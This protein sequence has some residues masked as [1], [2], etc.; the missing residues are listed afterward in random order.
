MNFSKKFAQVRCFLVLLDVGW[1]FCVCLLAIAQQTSLQ[2]HSMNSIVRANS[3]CSVGFFLLN[4]VRDGRQGWVFRRRLFH[5][6]CPLVLLLGFFRSCKISSIVPVSRHIKR[7]C[8]EVPETPNKIGKPLGLPSQIGAPDLGS[9]GSPRF[10]PMCSD[11]PVFFRFVPICAPCFRE[12]PDLFR[13]VPIFSDFFR[14]VPICFQNK[15]EQIRETPFCRPLLQISDQNAGQRS[16]QIPGRPC[17][18][19]YDLPSMYSKRIVSG[20]RMCVLCTK[21]TGGSF[22]TY[23]WSFFQL[24]F[25][26]Y[27]PLTC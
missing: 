19:K 11:F 2:K 3:C 27:S 7:T 23:S 21:E 22:F 17:H 12:Y 25:F 15:S 26:A 13:S 5:A 24:S 9:V 6:D 20:N 16:L 4:E 10:V 18:S 8:K 14:F 1:V